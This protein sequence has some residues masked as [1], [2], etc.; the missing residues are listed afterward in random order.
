VPLGDFDSTI[1]FR[2]NCTRASFSL[3]LVVAIVEAIIGKATKQERLQMLQ[4]VID[5]FNEKR[6]DEKNDKAVGGRK[7]KVANRYG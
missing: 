6:R 3:R 2:I 5:K 1:G 4:D 7:R